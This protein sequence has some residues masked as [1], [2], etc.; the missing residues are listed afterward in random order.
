MPK[1]LKL[2]NG[3]LVSVPDDATP[4]EMDAIANESFAP[5]AAHEPPSES[6]TARVG[7]FMTENAPMLLSG[8]L[9]ML[10]PASIPAQLAVAAG[11]GYLGSRLRGDDRTTA[12]WEGGKQGALQGAGMAASGLLAKGAKR[13]YS[14][15]LKPKQA[16]RE[17]FGDVAEA[18]LKE[19]IPITQRGLQTITD[20]MA[21]SRGQAMDLVKAA[22]ASGAPG[23]TAQEAVSEFGPV[24]SELRKRVDI[25]QPNELAK[26]G[27][28]GR[29]LMKTAQ[30]A[31]TSDIPLTR[32]QALKETAQEAASGAY[33]QLQHGAAKQ[34]S[35]DDL[36][37]KAVATGLRKGIE[38]K[39]PGIGAQNATTQRLLGI[40]RAIEDATA[41]DANNLGVGGMRDLIAAGV[42]GTAGGLLG[43]PIPGATAGALLMRALSTPSTGSHLAIG[44]ERLSRLPMAQLV[45]LAQLAALSGDL[46]PVSSHQP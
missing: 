32:A 15:L 24:V 7:R 3:A 2:P 33:R 39:V 41:R 1:T 11:G 20:R 14:G 40:T 6:S 26:V 30:T 38:T 10:A 9:T 12:A 46:A 21:Q 17:S 31:L 45:R 42:G 44:A 25:G 5:V 23:V 22:E 35:A 16:I 36:L 34:L 13:I 4:E 18:G 8:A 27:A 29:A 37:D 43:A 19:G 28:R